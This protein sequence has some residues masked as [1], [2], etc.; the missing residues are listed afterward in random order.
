[1]DSEFYGSI[2]VPGDRLADLESAVAKMARRIEKGKTVADYAPTIEAV[3]DHFIPRKD[4]EGVD[5]YHWVTVRYQTPAQEGWHLVAVYD[6]EVGPDGSR[7]C[8]T[9]PVPGQMVLSEYREAEPGQCDHCNINRARKKAMLITK[10][11]LDYMVVGTSCIKDFL[12]HKSAAS[13]VDLFT[14]HKMIAN[15]RNSGFSGQPEAYLKAVEVVTAASMYVR[16]HGYV[17]AG[18]WDDTPTADRVR[19]HMFPGILRGTLDVP[20]V[21]DEQFALDAIEHIRSQGFSSDYIENCVKA[22]DAGW[23]TEKRIGLLASIPGV[24]KAHRERQEANKGPTL[25]EY[26]GEIKERLRGVQATVQ[27]VRYTEGMYGTTSIITLK[28]GEGRTLIW[29]ASGYH[30]PETGEQWTLDGTVKAH[31]E[32]KGTLQTVLTRVKY[33]ETEAVA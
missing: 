17:K 10:D 27:R 24:Y 23:T 13:F 2:L 3:R 4:G 29:F 6:W 19:R 32:F 5:P 16:Q 8:Y 12:G 25:N 33:T 20:T 30:E 18:S 28:D 21:E 31:N 9:S 26:R 7:T 1:M 14:F 15:V 11:F 22:L